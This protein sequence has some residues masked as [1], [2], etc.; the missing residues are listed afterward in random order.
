MMADAEASAM[1]V[2]ATPEMVEAIT[3]QLSFHVDLEAATV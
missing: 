1:G 2:M 3:E